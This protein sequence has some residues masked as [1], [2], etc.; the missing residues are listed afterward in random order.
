MIVVNF[1][2][3]FAAIIVIIARTRAEQ[4]IAIATIKSIVSIIPT[5]KNIITIGSDCV[6]NTEISVRS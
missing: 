1:I 6:L 5:G 4:I 3:A 2:V